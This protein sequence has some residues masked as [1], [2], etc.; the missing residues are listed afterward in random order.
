MFSL[1][2]NNAP[3]CYS[4]RPQDEGAGPTPPANEK[5]RSYKPNART[6]VSPGGEQAPKDAERAAR[7]RR[8]ADDR[9]RADKVRLQREAQQQK[10]KDKEDQKKREEEEAKR[11][12]GA[13]KQEQEEK[14]RRAQEE[15]REERRWKEDEEEKRRAGA[16]ASTPN[17][18][19]VGGFCFVS[20]FFNYTSKAVAL[21]FEIWLIE[22][23]DFRQKRNYSEKSQT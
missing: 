2:N 7:A 8:E 4:N 13:G 23:L 17:R 12:K 16:K 6:N 3:I 18:H 15:R 14:K 11:K 1:S 5:Q 10:K 19:E 9:E 20:V 22:M 21:M